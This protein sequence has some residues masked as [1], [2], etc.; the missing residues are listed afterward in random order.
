MAEAATSLFRVDRESELPVG[1]Q[2]AWSVRALIA[3][4][5]LMPGDRLPGVRRLA[6]EAGVNPNTARAIY[7][8]LEAEGLVETR[9][10]LGTFVAAGAASSTEVER[11]AADAVAEARRAGVSPADVARA[12]YGARWAAANPPAPGQDPPD[13]G[14]E[15]DEAAARRELRRQIAR[16]EAELA[17]YPEARP[18]SETH[19]LLRPKGHLPDFA[20][21]S[22][23]RDGLIER[24]RG[25]RKDAERKGE[26]QARAHARRERVLGDPE[27]QRWVRVRTE[28][29]GDPGCGETAA[30]PRFGPLG[31]L[32]GWWR[33]KVSSGCP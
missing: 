8:R 11:I 14:A 1:I 5:K 28:D 7:G 13:V 12:I 10:G 15:A 17:A 31:A 18:D 22:A 9:H 21:L 16:L 33:V 30:V 20:E 6:E 3:S 4:G 32:A 24:L 2:V 26:R 19:P 29:C 27:S 23:V 25:A